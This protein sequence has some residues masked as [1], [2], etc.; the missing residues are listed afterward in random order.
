VITL[1]PI[2]DVPRDSATLF[3]Y[4]GVEHWD[5]PYIQ[6]LRGPVGHYDL[7]LAHMMDSKDELT[8]L[9][10]A[11]SFPYIHDPDLVRS[12]FQAPKEEAAWVDWRTLTTLGMTEVWG[13]QNTAAVSRLEKVVGVP[14]RYKGNSGLSSYSI[15]DPPTWGDV[16]L[17]YLQDLAPCKYYIAVGRIHGAGQGAVDAASLNCICIG[18]ADKA[19]HQLIC[20]PLALCADM[21]ELPQRTRRILASSDLQIEILA[22]QEQALREQ[23]VKRPLGILTDALDIKRRRVIQTG[24]ASSRKTAES[25]AGAGAK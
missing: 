6:S 25:L 11:I 23:F 12:L 15:T 4:H 10:Q 18:Q 14:V 7:F 19:Y 21:S 20:H 2:L 8:G 16:A 13:S 9:P 22:W 24:G 1:D 5:Q 3:A 17:L